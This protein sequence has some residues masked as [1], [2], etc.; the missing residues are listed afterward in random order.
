VTQDIPKA[1]EQAFKN[2]LDDIEFVECEMGSLGL[3]EAAVG[4]GQVFG[5]IKGVSRLIA[6][7]QQILFN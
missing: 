4:L 5:E 3:D 6:Y 7:V 2:L 1:N